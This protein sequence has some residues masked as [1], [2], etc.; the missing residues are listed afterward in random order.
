MSSLRCGAVGIASASGTEGP[1]SNP[2][3]VNVFKAM[4]LCKID[5]ISIVSVLKNKN[6]GIGTKIFFKNFLHNMKDY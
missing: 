4:L 2:A 6:S 1:G 5:L 3:R